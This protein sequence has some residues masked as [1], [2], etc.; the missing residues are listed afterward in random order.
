MKQDVKLLLD[1]GSGMTNEN[2]HLKKGEVRGDH[3]HRANVTKLVKQRGALGEQDPHRQ[4]RRPTPQRAGLLK[5]GK[6][7]WTWEQ[8]RRM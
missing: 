3:V 7:Q 6:D 4:Y 5:S 8:F 2:L 1:S